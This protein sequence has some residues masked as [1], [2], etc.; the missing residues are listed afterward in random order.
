MKKT[1][2]GVE[3]S[4]LDVFFGR[5]TTAE[6]ALFAAATHRDTPYKLI[7]GEGYRCCEY[8]K[9]INIFSFGKTK[10][11]LPFT[12]IAPPLSIDRVGYLGE[13]TALIS[14]YSR[15][16]ELF[17]ILNVRQNYSGAAACA[18]T[19]SAAVLT[20]RFLNFE[21]YVKNLRSHYRRR[22]LL[23]EKK[24]ATLR[25]KRVPSLEFNQELY[26][27]YLQVLHHSDFPLET[28]G[29]GFFRGCPGEIDAL[30][31][32]EQKPVA[33]VLTSHDEVQTTFVFGGM[34]YSQRDEYDL[35]YNMMSK[36]LRIGFENLSQKIDFGQTAENTKRR[37]GCGLE[38]RFMLFFTGVPLLTGLAK[39]LIRLIEYHPGK[40]IYHVFK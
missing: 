39:K 7:M 31:D 19:L 1:F 32:P 14:D 29:I 17:L 30:Y 34:D 4:D 2:E 16:K 3:C 5:E 20:N 12:V 11:T 38:P 35:Y 21:E 10:L 18:H 15:R 28:L 37:L 13:L 33:F 40:E 9:M 27:L 26:Q 25:W 8:K 22:L 6:K 36:V 23:A 24:G